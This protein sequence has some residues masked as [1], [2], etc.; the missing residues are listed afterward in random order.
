VPAL[1]DTRLSLK[2]S[3]AGARGIAR[4]RKVLSERRRHVVLTVAVCTWNRAPLLRAVLEDLAD[5]WRATGGPL[6]VLVIDNNCTDDTA[7]VVIEF[8]SRL[9]IRRVLE[10]RQGNGAA[11]NRAISEARGTVIVYL[12]DDVRVRAGWLQAYRDAFADETVIAAG[13]R[14]KP[15]WPDRVPR[16]IGSSAIPPFQTIVPCVDLGDEPIDV[17]DIARVPVTANLG[18][19][20]S[21]LEALGRF[22]EDLGNVGN[23]P[24]GGE[25]TELLLR[26]LKRYGAVRYLPHAIV[27]HP[28]LPYRMSFW[29]NMRYLYGGGAAE[30]H[31]E[32]PLPGTALVFGVP[33]WAL[34]RLARAGL[35]ACVQAICLNPREAAIAAGRV[36]GTAGYVRALIRHR[37]VA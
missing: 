27:D 14:I 18:F 35:R 4:G 24:G 31:Y 23:R 9:P 25:D 28:V 20:V 1:E 22:R 33:R 17:T 7:A 29:F 30:A 5:D 26:Y 12:D 19:R 11:R 2:P 6:D 15:V 34:G 37:A 8:A 36:A 21:A 32:P 10:P 16:W 3:L 13:G